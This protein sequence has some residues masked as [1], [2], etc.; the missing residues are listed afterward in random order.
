MILYDSSLDLPGKAWRES[1]LLIVTVFNPSLAKRL[2]SV[3]LYLG[4]GGRLS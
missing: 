4:T 3:R 1:F 2:V